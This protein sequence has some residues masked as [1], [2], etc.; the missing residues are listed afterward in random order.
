[1][2]NTAQAIADILAQLPPEP[3]LRADSDENAPP[4]Q[5]TGNPGIIFAHQ[6][7]TFFEL[8]KTSRAFERENWFALPVLPR[9]HTLL[10][11][12]TGTGKSHLVRSLGAFLGWET[13]TLWVTRWIISGARGKETWLEVGKWLAAQN[14]KC[15]LFLDELDKLQNDS[16]LWGTHL[17]TEIFEL[18][19]RDLPAGLELADAE[20]ESSSLA[21]W[22]KAQKVLRCDCLILG[23]GAFQSLW[24]FRPQSLGFREPS[25]EEG[26]PSQQE[27]KSVI[28]PEL[29]NRFGKIL[30]L[31]P[32]MEADYLAMSHRTAEVL[33]GELRRKF[34]EIA[35][36]KLAEAIR[37]G[38]GAR[39][40]EQCVTEA[41]LSAAEEESTEKAGASRKKRI[42]HRNSVSTT[43]EGAV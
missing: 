10:V 41:L 39:F 4:T 31:P 2:D 26:I 36:K 37:E 19:D 24:D 1:M 27:L 28:P 25:A 11:G 16:S 17:R 32:L 18:L 34:L 22:A 20:G 5:P 15:I 23:A 33:P 38:R 9:W 21:M 30:V 13:Y 43:E 6:R 12:S 14:G 8:I 42:L 40:C 7:S 3:A 29:V 35:E